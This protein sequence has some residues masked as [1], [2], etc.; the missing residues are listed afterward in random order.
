M[1]DLEIKVRTPKTFEV[2]SELRDNLEDLRLLVAKEYVTMVL[3][4]Q[5]HFSVI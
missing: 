2:E 3:G 5:M 4:T 1:V